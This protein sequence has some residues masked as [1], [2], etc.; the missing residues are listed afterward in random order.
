MFHVEHRTMKIQIESPSTDDVV[1]L[2]TEHLQEMNAQSPAC[3]VH[4][5][6]VEA[7]QS[8]DVTFWTVRDNGSLMACGALKRI[9]ETCSEIKSMR[10]VR[11][12]RRQGVAKSLLSHFFSIAKDSG[13][14]RLMLETGSQDEFEP[15]RKLYF[16]V[17]FV[18]C[19]PFANYT[20]DPNSFYMVKTM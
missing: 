13:I 6:D 18:E 1:D 8:H 14:G 2:L 5:L 11:E 20:D 7:L 19:G 15:A 17:G 10:T 12:Y 16:S 3:S 9:D 4:A